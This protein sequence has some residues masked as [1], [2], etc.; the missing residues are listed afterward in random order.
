VYIQFIFLRSAQLYIEYSQFK[1]SLDHQHQHLQLQLQLQR[2]DD[3]QRRG[4]IQKA[5][6]RCFWGNL[7]F[8]MI[9]YCVSA[10]IVCYMTSS[11]SSSSSSSSSGSESEG[12]GDISNTNN[13]GG[14]LD[15]RAS[16]IV[17][18]LS[19]LFAGVISLML[20]V[21]I[22]QWLGVYK[23]VIVD[24]QKRRIDD[25]DNDDDDDRRATYYYNFKSIRELK[26]DFSY[27]LQNRLIACYSF[28]LYFSCDTN[29]DAQ[30]IK[31]GTLGGILLG[32]C[33]ILIVNKSRTH[34]IIKQ[35]RYLIAIFITT[36]LLFSSLICIGLGIYF[37]ERVWREDRTTSTNNLAAVVTTLV[38]L[39]VPKTTFRICCIW[40][41]I[42]C[43]GVHGAAMY[44]SHNVDTSTIKTA[45]QNIE[46]T[47][48]IAATSNNNKNDKNGSKIRRPASARY[49][50][51]VF[52]EG[53]P[54]LKQIKKLLTQ[55]KENEGGEESDKIQQTTMPNKPTPPPPS[56]LSL[57]TSKINEIYGFGGGGKTS[58][59]NNNIDDNKELSTT[60][61]STSTLLSLFQFGR[62]IHYIVWYITSIFFLFMTIVNIGSTYQQNIVRLNLNGAF[63]KL[64]PSDYHTGK[65][66]AWDNK[67]SNGHIR[68]FNTLEEVTNNYTI[69]HCG[70]CAACSNWNDLKL[71]W[72]TRNVLAKIARKWYVHAVKR[73]FIKYKII[74]STVCRVL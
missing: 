34:P 39:E 68:T 47:T 29:G 55:D 8:G 11:P 57:I 28:H 67:S 63:T 62:Q 31:Y 61:T 36:I 49:K 2:K 35:Y 13:G 56:Y 12:I 64:Y 74:N 14:G 18:G 72:T 59:S 22:C 23:T 60:S 52:Q 53:A 1:L 37:I 40:V 17:T 71:Q 50:S 43:F 20:S 15:R 25:D 3:P 30:S 45:A 32:T 19:R 44:L 4:M 10:S 5:L 24:S 33:F 41:G 58:S 42:V 70:E 27:A 26:F 69:I 7:I 6:T 38:E 54:G 66:C 65:M 46:S 73:V 48:I 9:L 21:K 51:E 16:D